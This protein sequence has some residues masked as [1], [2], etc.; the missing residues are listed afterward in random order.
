M[1]W[2]IDDSRGV[3]R[4]NDKQT[5]HICN[6]CCVIDSF[7]SWSICKLVGLFKGTNCTHKL[8]EV[9]KFR[10]PKIQIQNRWNKSDCDQI[11]WEKVGQHSL[12]YLQNAMDWRHIQE[13]YR[14][15]Q[16][17]EV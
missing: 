1:K 17:I 9:T 3:T 2:I 13:C 10:T 6:M 4:L 5:I 14:N 16:S 12:M 11:D 7:C 8:V 15:N